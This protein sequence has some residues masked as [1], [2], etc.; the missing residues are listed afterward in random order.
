MSGSLTALKLVLF[1]I[2]TY[3][4]NRQVTSNILLK[5]FKIYP[6]KKI[7]K[8]FYLRIHMH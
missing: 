2:L 7:M 1:V 3:P 6:T 5:N 4:I 8:S